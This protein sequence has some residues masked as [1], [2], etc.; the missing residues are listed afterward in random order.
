[1]KKPKVVRRRLMGL[2]ISGSS[3]CSPPLVH[4]IY[5]ECTFEKGMFRSTLRRGESI[6]VMQ[7]SGMLNGSKREKAFHLKAYRP[8]LFYSIQAAAVLYQQLEAACLQL[9]AER[10]MKEIE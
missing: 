6:Q 10:G 3:K 9:D 8:D 5:E 4:A 2:W 1:M 7:H